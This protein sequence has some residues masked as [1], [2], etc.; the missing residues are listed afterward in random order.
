MEYY[1]KDLQITLNF[2]G[3]THIDVGTTYNNI[4][5]AFKKLGK[6]ILTL[7]SLM[8]LFLLNILSIDMKR[9]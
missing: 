6:Y 2:V 8:N 3:E 9:H 1:H 7:V 5:L 4:G